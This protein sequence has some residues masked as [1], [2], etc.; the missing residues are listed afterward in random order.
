[1]LA[2]LRF[3]ARHEDPFKVLAEGKAACYV[4]GELFAEL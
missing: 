2:L 1:M 3:L 4:T